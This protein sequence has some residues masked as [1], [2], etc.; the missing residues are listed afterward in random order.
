MENTFL[1]TTV[2]DFV[3]P[4]RTCESQI[5]SDESSTF[6]ISNKSKIDVSTG[7]VDSASP[8]GDDGADLNINGTPCTSHGLLDLQ[9]RYERR[10]HYMTCQHW[11]QFQSLANTFSR[12][13]H[14]TSWL[15]YTCRWIYLPGYEYIFLWFLKTNTSLMDTLLKSSR[16]SRRLMKE[17]LIIKS[18][19]FFSQDTD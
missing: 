8:C 2:R 19:S 3:G 6:T 4:N 1:I 5:C 11:F 17:L 12:I 9:P 14:Q 7:Q 18:K 10:L 16:W 15:S 13:P